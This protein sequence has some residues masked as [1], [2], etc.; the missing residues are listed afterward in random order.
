M[1]HTIHYQ[2]FNDFL[3][4]MDLDYFDMS[5]VRFIIEE[6]CTDFKPITNNHILSAILIKNNGI[7]GSGFWD[8]GDIKRRIGT[9]SKENFHKNELRQL[10]LSLSSYNCD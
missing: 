4:S 10:K 6:I 3:N 1:E 7:S 2:V 8:L 9:E 5:D